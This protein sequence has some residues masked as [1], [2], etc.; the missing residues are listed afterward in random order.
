MLNHV[1]LE[2]DVP[3][4]FQAPQRI[5]ALI[6]RNLLVTM[7]CPKEK[8]VGAYLFTCENHLETLTTGLDILLR[9]LTETFQLS[10]SAV[11]VR[12]IGLSS[13][14][15]I[16]TNALKKWCA[17]KKVT[18]IGEDLGRNVQR[19]IIIDCESGKVGVSYA[20][21]SPNEKTVLIADG[22]AGERSGS[23]R[24]R[25]AL[26]LGE[27]RTGRQMCRQA[28][29]SLDTWRA[30]IHERPFDLFV[31]PKWEDFD[32]DAVILL[33]DV[34]EGKPVQKWFTKLIE[35]YPSSKRIWVGDS[36]KKWGLEIEA[37]PS[38]DHDNASK[39]QEQ[40]RN[41]LHESETDPGAKVI[42]F[43]AT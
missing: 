34:G 17:E 14:N 6:N 31:A 37:L 22:T 25:R 40:L 28:V 19:N 26:I 3:L 8:V 10:P 18:V 24:P 33:A 16:L 1:S 12:V 4:L 27:S 39:F 42:R 11:Q 2:A 15:P 20:E 7:S 43:T 13:P 9:K 23:H 5:N 38:V 36:P 41:S 29:E 30:T 32:F 21:A 35:M